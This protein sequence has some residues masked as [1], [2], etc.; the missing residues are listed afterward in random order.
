MYFSFSGSPNVVVVECV[1]RGEV[2]ADRQVGGEAQP[3][4]LVGE[5]RER[6][7]HRLAQ[8]HAAPAGS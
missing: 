4:L 8:D 6:A 1:G 5:E 3:D 7:A 2:V